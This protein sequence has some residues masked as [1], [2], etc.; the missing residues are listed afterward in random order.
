MERPEIALESLQAMV[1]QPTLEDYRALVFE[2]VAMA[3]PTIGRDFAV[4]VVEEGGNVRVGL[5]SSTL[6]GEMFIRYLRGNLPRLIGLAR[7]QK[8]GEKDDAKP[9][10]AAEGGPVTVL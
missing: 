6:A 7:S 3:I 4:R 2:A 5:S 10:E 8:Y 1:R 9:D